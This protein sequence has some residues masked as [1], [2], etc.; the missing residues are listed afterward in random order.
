[1]NRE[2]SNGADENDDDVYVGEDDDIE[3]EPVREVRRKKRTDVVL[4]VKKTTG[5]TVTKKAPVPEFVKPV[6]A[7]DSA[8][9]GAHNPRSNSNVRPKDAALDNISG[10]S[11]E[12]PVP[13]GVRNPPPKEAEL[14]SKPVKKR[15]RADKEVQAEAPIDNRAPSR[16]TAIHPD[17]Y[18]EMQLEQAK[19]LLLEMQITAVENKNILSEKIAP[20]FPNIS[21]PN[22]SI[23]TNEK[24]DLV[25]GSAFH[26]LL[27]EGSRPSKG[28]Y[29]THFEKISRIQRWF[30]QV[31]KC[32]AYAALLRLVNK[33][34]NDPRKAYNQHGNGLGLPK[35]ETAKVYASIGE[36]ILRYPE[37]QYQTKIIDLNKWKRFA[38]KDHVKYSV[39]V[40]EY[41]LAI[42]L[43]TIFNGDVRIARQWRS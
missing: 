27:V 39:K 14:S 28:G 16:K 6:K 23:A 24:L 4:S 25:T 40:N 3:E 36:L 11:D 34:N 31:E 12:P 15:G 21:E 41:N 26:T 9:M 33:D 1:M 32:Y 2:E 43:E 19:Q 35:F 13:K 20:Q 10:V 37:L 22:R 7:A 18:E 30:W 42:H 5:K 8:F 29:D 38:V 17:D